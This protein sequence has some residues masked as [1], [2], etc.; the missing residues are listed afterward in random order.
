MRDI[1]ATLTLYI[2][3]VFLPL[4]AQLAFAFCGYREDYNIIS[5]SIHILRMFYDNRW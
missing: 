3:S 1:N 5:R 2:G 4:I